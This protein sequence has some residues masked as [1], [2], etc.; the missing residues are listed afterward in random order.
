MRSK[1]ACRMLT[2]MRRMFLRAKITRILHF[3]AAHKQHWWEVAC[4]ESYENACDT[5]FWCCFQLAYIKVLFACVS[6]ER[7]RK[8]TSDANHW[9]VSRQLKQWKKSQLMHFGGSI[10]F[11]RM[12]FFC[13]FIL[14]WWIT[15]KLRIKSYMHTH[16]HTWLGPKPENSILGKNVERLR[17]QNVHI[18]QCK[19]RI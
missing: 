2:N 3:E 7:E 16:T 19:Q 11:V 10:G 13:V 14:L 18:A 1:Y 8:K 6:V 12:R 9:W 5:M 17:D 4:G 15:R